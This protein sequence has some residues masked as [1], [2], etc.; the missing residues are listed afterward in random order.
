VAARNRRATDSAQQPVVLRRDGSPDL[1]VAHV[2]HSLGAG[3][4]EAVLGELARAAPSAGMRP[5]IVGL[6]DARLGTGVDRRGVSQLREHGA[7]V[8][9]M[10]G[11]RYSP[12]QA[13][14]LAR[15]LRDE[16]VDIV[17]THLK[18]ADVVG[19]VAARLARLPSVS[20]LH[21][22]DVPASWAD[23]LRVEAA[24][25]ARRRLSSAVIALSSEQRRWYCQYA[26]ADAPITVL[27][28]GVAEPNV[29]Q[30]RAS[31]RDQLGVPADAVFA[32]SVSLM[33]PEKGHADLLEA[34]RE[35]P[36]DL[37][38]VLA[39]AG[40]GPLLESVRATVDSDPDLRKRARILGYRRDV[41]NL[42]AACDF[43]VQ[44]SLEDALPTAL[45]SALAA[46]RPIVGTNVGGI[47]DIVA[48]GCGFLVDAGHP[49]ALSDG[50]ARMA[51]L[52]HTDASA[53]EAMRR[54]ARERY[55]SYFSA[56]VWVQNLRS[57][58]EE[59]LNIR[60]TPAI[61]SPGLRGG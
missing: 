33:R 53:L 42:L 7:T 19:G 38:L 6:S 47:P 60:R 16:R 58:Y 52:I 49:S 55:E 27:P 14:T 1:T 30:D 44:P 50:I 2:I 4:A 35:L 5:I 48:P 10:H 15:L 54:V 61:C 32:L 45:I 9:E 43:V 59:A 28:N 18:H 56:D 37:P 12:G 23:R 46:G 26:G 8:Y 39:M 57:V 31:T 20:T 25:L 22:I 36:D 21:V 24:V 17:H 3:G 29:T 11:A 51:R 34:I 13:V 41:A 40:D